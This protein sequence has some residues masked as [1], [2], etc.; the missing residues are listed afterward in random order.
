MGVKFT[1]F[2][3]T[4]T[5]S[6]INAVDTALT[7]ASGAV[8]PSLG[9]GDFFYAV[10]VDSLTAPTKREIVK[11]TARSGDNLTI[12]RAQD[13]S[14]ADDWTAGSYIE[15][16]LVNAA[17]SALTTDLESDLANVTTTT[18][19]DYKIGFVQSD[20]AGTFVTGADT[21]TVSDKLTE[22]LSV[23]D[24]G[25][26]G[27]GAT[28][29]T[30]AINAA[31]A[32]VNTTTVPS[33][34]LVFPPG[35]YMITSA[36]SAITRG[37]T[38]I[39]G[40]GADINIAHATA[41]GLLFEGTALSP[42]N[43]NKVVGLRFYSYFSGGAGVRTGGF[44][45]KFKY[46]YFPNIHDV[47]ITDQF[48]AI[49]LEGYQYVSMDACK[50]DGNMTGVYVLSGDGLL[51][52]NTAIGYTAAATYKP[53]A[54]GFDLVVGGGFYF[55]NVDVT[56][57]EYGIYGRP[58]DT[59]NVQYLFFSNTAL[60]T[61][62]YGL[63]LDASLTVTSGGIHTVHADSGSWFASAV[64]DA[65]GGVGVYMNDVDRV[66]FNGATILHN[67]SYGAQFK[68]C[69]DI[70]IIGCDVLN[71][72][73]S[74][75][76][77]DCGG[78]FFDTC[79][80]VDVVSN[81]FSNAAY[82]TFQV[83]QDNGVKLDTTTKVKILNNRFESHVVEDITLTTV[84]AIGTIQGNTTSVTNTIAS[85][86]GAITIPIIHDLVFVSG[87]AAITDLTTVKLTG[88]QLTLVTTGTATIAD[89]ANTIL[90]GTFTGAAG[91]VLSLICDGTTYN[92]VSRSA[93][94]RGNYNVADL[95]ASGNFLMSGSAKTFQGDFDNAT[96]G[97]RTR[98]QTKTTN[99]NT[100][101]PII[102]NGTGTSASFTLANTSD[103]A[104]SALAQVS[105][106]STNNTIVRNNKTG[107]GTY[108]DI[109]FQTSGINS[110]ATI[111][112]AGDIVLGKRSALATTATAE[113]LYV[114]SCA[115]TPTGVPSG[116]TGM[117]P[118]VVDSTNNKL[119]FYS[120]GA[121]RDA[122]P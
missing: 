27:D 22:F 75:S 106:D 69:R 90:Y 49:H 18:K 28:D 16:R 2:A 83:Y 67:N 113:L 99:A 4:T 121:W 57:M 86:A 63:Y 80:G 40:Y 35:T 84:P 107:T 112:S 37:N 70:K 38:T 94:A 60:D 77:A 7:V 109:E 61:C 118:L 91:A 11:V 100:S 98:V 88:K 9:A 76:V 59:Y 97:N 13:A 78:L 42:D 44:A 5:T 68:S 34:E 114:P 45:V 24:F 43:Y 116:Y 39:S 48:V 81:L 30:S 50:L 96:L 82:G 17:I 56:R 95:D 93:V 6:T 85:A 32:H 72:N 71:N 36:L 89:S 8:F 20:I 102:P 66:V 53:A 108:G 58:P 64:Y 103:L 74:N 54:K 14:V 101:F 79:T 115:G 73:S 25:A 65:G 29:D 23:K 111:T 92:E 117:V 10:L 120:N 3:S 31:I 52:T 47:V 104:N 46:N 12:V 15:L 55:S 62:K 1:N 33:V 19:G 51:V 87:V 26:V 105:I 41:D 110:R 119:Y 122:G 21:K